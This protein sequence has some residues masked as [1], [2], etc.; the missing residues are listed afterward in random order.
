MKKGRKK[1]GY[2]DYK[3]LT[4]ILKTTIAL[5][6]NLT[7]YARFYHR[8]RLVPDSGGIFRCQVVFLSI[9]ALICSRF[10]N[11]KMGRRENWARDVREGSQRLGPL[12]LLLYVRKSFN[13]SVRRSFNRCST[14]SQLL[15]GCLER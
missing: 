13:R 2:L 7:L 14:V 4:Q 15:Y 6:Q 1:R 8:D 11:M 10:Y 3:T 12:H 9:R 5:W